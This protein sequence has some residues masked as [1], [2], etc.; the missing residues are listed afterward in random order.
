VGDVRVQDIRSVIRTKLTSGELPT[1]TPE[2]CW[3]GKGTS[4]P[5]MACDLAINPDT[6]EYEVD[7]PTPAPHSVTTLRLH[8][9]C[10][11]V[12]HEERVHLRLKQ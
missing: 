1:E 10:L 12:W 5:C 11:T 2:K 7:L 4:R 9:A 8:Q 3:V 6:L